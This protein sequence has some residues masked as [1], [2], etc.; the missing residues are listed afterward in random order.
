[1]KTNW[2]LWILWVPVLLFT[3][4][5]CAA[6]IEWDI[7]RAHSSVFFDVRH[8]FATVRGQ[9]NDFSGTILIDPENHGNSRIDMEVKVASINTNNRQR[10]N[11]L[12]SEEFFS[13]KKYPLMTFNTAKV[14]QV[15]DN[16]YELA[17]KLTVKDVTKDV[18]V[19]FIY[20]GVKDNPL[21]PKQ[22]VAGFEGKFT[23]DRLDYNVGNGQFHKMGVIGKNVDI[24]IT[25]EVLK[26]K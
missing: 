2:S 16:L 9:F 4:A 8:T 11:H 19:P 18:V 12:R 3:S 14:K 24:I 20:Y 21:N 25:L 7:D 5:V 26:N 6:P 1:M 17:G 13:A 15:K 10:D 22:L 23:I